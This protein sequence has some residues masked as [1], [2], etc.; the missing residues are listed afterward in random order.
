MPDIES[1]P[2]SRRDDGI[3]PW[4]QQQR[5][6]GAV[7]LAGGLLV[8]AVACL[9][10]QQIQGGQRDALAATSLWGTYYQSYYP[11]APP[12][13]YYPQY[14]YPY[15][16]LAPARPPSPPAQSLV[17]K[18]TAPYYKPTQNIKAWGAQRVKFEVARLM[19]EED[20][21]VKAEEKMATAVAT[22]AQEVEQMKVQKAV[23]KVDGD[24]GRT[25][26]QLVKGQPGPPGKTGASGATGAPGMN[27]AT[28]L[29]GPVEY[30]PQPEYPPPQLTEYP[31]YGGPPQGDQEQAPA[32]LVAPALSAA[33]NQATQ[34]ATAKELAAATPKTKAKGSPE[35]LVVQSRMHPNPLSGSLFAVQVPDGLTAGKIFEAEVPGHGLEAVKVPKGV[36]SGQV[37]DIETTDPAK[38]K[39]HYAD[40]RKS[41]KP[42]KKA[43]LTVSMPPPAVPPPV[44]E[45]IKAPPPLNSFQREQVRAAM[46]HE[47][48]QMVVDEALKVDRSAD[49]REAEALSTSSSGDPITV[50]G[51]RALAAT[52]VAP[53]A[54]APTHLSHEAAIE[55]AARPQTGHAENPS[56]PPAQVVQ[57]TQQHALS[58]EHMPP[59]LK[60]AALSV[61]RMVTEQKAL[62]SSV[63]QLEQVASNFITAHAKPVQT[64]GRQIELAD[65]SALRQMHAMQWSSGARAASRAAVEEQ[66][67]AA[68]HS[69]RKRKLLQ[70][71][72][73]QRA[74]DKGDDAA[75]LAQRV[76]D[77]GAT[78]N[79][80]L[81][82]NPVLSAHPTWALPELR[83]PSPALQD[84]EAPTSQLQWTP[85]VPAG[86]PLQPQDSTL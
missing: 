11:A 52:V 1:P 39:Q 16:Q 58:V 42:A 8:V 48:Y 6:R 44:K 20:L 66:Q 45:P 40:S 27:G 86:V 55:G 34:Q 24:N 81:H 47:T 17:A 46:G 49:K 74:V 25:T 7:L 50:N 53:A 23:E 72:V 57:Q 71:T 13:T 35:E 60:K 56:V 21:S 18:V 83:A 22:L 78:W 84:I 15:Q 3:T 82:P 9:A 69:V 68:V 67:Q 62:Q 36:H 10:R 32:P 30:V 75:E 43:R 37:I 54:P 79:Q 41:T 70:K 4:P 2:S 63:S 19:K 80:I 28:G 64:K 5:R 51:A 73:V 65:V 85:F 31:P 26:T 77:M 76:T 29:P 61:H 12:Y 14:Q 38:L 59:A 33:T